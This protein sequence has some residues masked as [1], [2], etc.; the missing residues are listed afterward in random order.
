MIFYEV[1]A[2]L[3]DPAHWRGQDGV[4]VRIAEHLY[5]TAVAVLTASVVAVPVGLL[6]GVAWLVVPAGIRVSRNAAATDRRMKWASASP[7]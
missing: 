1:V 4:A 3:A 7:P 6:A 2:W 5:Y